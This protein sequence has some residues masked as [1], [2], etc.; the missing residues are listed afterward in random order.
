MRMEYTVID[1]KTGLAIVRYFDNAKSP[2]LVID[3]GASERLTNFTA[4]LAKAKK[5]SDERLRKANKAN[6]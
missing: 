4:R 1:P 3:E 6:T 2:G 5:E